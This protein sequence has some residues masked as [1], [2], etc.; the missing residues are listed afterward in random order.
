MFGAMGYE[1]L[2]H[3]KYPVEHSIKPLIGQ[4]GPTP[5]AFG[6][7]VVAA[8]GGGSFDSDDVSGRGFKHVQ[9]RRPLSVI[10]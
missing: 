5:P 2:P 4:Y 9:A 10:R 3:C 1:I 8:D 6:E 7:G